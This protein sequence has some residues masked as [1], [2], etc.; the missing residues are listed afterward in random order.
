MVVMHAV[1]RRLLSVL[2]AS[3]VF[4]PGQT[5]IVGTYNVRYDN[6]GDAERGN[7]WAQRAPVIGELIKFHQFDVLGTQEALHHQVVDLQERLP[8]FAHVGMGRDDGEKKGEFTA[9]FYKK[10]KFRLLDS[11]TFW[12]SPT[13]DKVGVIGWD[14]ALPRICTWV[15]LRESAGKER[16]FWMFNVP[17]DHR[18]VQARLESSRLVLAKIDEL[19]A[20]EPVI[21]TGDFNVTQTSESYNEIAGSE[22]FSDAYEGAPIRYAQNGTFSNFDPN[23][24]TDSR[25]DHVFLTP[26]FKPLRYGVLLDTYRARPPGGDAA[27]PTGNAP[28]EV[29]LQEYQS[30][31]PSDHFPVLVEVELAP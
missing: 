20:G 7:G 31:L 24:K 14:A 2:I 10:D 13:P 30:R 21:F 29:K 5:L 9:I 17:F 4:A 8:E 11:G 3:A 1:F 26:H 15:K 23:A 19:A 22:S 18:G 6:P 27:T 28:E 25:I 12:L 16:A